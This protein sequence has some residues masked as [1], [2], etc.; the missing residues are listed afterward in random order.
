MLRLIARW[1]ITQV[2]LEFLR[3]RLRA[4]GSEPRWTGET[5]GPTDH[6][7]L[8]PDPQ[9]TL[10]EAAPIEAAQPH[11]EPPPLPKRLYGM[12]LKVAAGLDLRG[13][14]LSGLDLRRT[15]LRAA[16]LHGAN[17]RG[18]NLS[19]A[20]LDGAWLGGFWHRGT[21][22]EGANL[23]DANLERAFL[24][25]ANLAHADLRDANLQ[26]AFLLDTDVSG[27]DLRGAD[28]RRARLVGVNLEEARL[29]NTLLPD[30]PLT[31]ET[32]TASRTYREVNIRSTMGYNDPAWVVAFSPQSAGQPIVFAALRIGEEILVGRRAD[33]DLRPFGDLHVSRRHAR[34]IA[35]PSALLLTDLNSTNGMLVNGELLAVEQPREL[36]DDDT[37]SFGPFL[38]FIVRIVKRPDEWR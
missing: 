25:F 2:R 35:G 27:A 37:V 17:L 19:G 28:L 29:G 14:N 3:W 12:P 6:R 30:D 13:V 20:N 23:R 18:A 10:V 5:I 33:V 8:Q 4:S 11:P 26:N 36:K 15:D 31:S 32:H 34:L 16:H 38:Q 21:D 24:C 22:L 7:V 9:T 1:L